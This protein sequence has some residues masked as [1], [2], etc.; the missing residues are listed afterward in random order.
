MFMNEDGWP[1]VAAHRYAGA[2]KGVKFSAKDLAGTWKYINHGTRITADLTESSL[3]ELHPDGTVSGAVKGT[4][5]LEKKDGHNYAAFNL[6][7]HTFKGVFHYQYDPDN[8]VNRLTF[9]A[10]GPTNETVWGSKAD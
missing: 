6:D 8:N 2:I 4:W 3:I 5:K 7:G 1:V 10:C 9:S